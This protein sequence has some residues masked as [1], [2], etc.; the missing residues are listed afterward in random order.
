VNKLAALLSASA[1][2]FPAVAQ[3]Q[4]CRIDTIAGGGPSFAGNGGAALGAELRPGGSVLRD[5]GGLVHFI[6]YGSG[7]ILRITADERLETVVGSD[8]GQSGDGRPGPQTS[9]DFI[10][11]F[12]FAPDGALY[13]L[14]TSL[15]AELLRKL[16]LGGVVET[17]AGEHAADF[18]GDGGP[19]RD[20]GLGGTIDFTISP[21]GSIYL[22]SRAPSRTNTGRVRRISP[23]GLIETVAGGGDPFERAEVDWSETGPA[24]GALFEIPLQ[25]LAEPD[26]SVLVRDGGRAPLRRLRPDGTIEPTPFDLDRRLRIDGRGRLYWAEGDT[27]YRA[28]AD[29]RP[30]AIWTD[31]N[32]VRVVG[33][34]VDLDGNLWSGSGWGL[35][36]L[37]SDGRRLPAAGVSRTM[38][39]AG[40]GGPALQASFWPRHLSLGP[41]GELVLFDTATNRIRVV[42][43]GVISAVAGNGDLGPLVEGALAVETPLGGLAGGVSA[44]VEATAVLPNGEVLFATRGVIWRVGADSILSRFA[45]TPA[46]GCGASGFCRDGVP[47]RETGLGD[48][49]EMVVDGEGVVYLS[50][51]G[52]LDRILRSITPDGIITNI[53]FQWPTEQARLL[54]D[55]D[56]RLVIAQLHGRS[57]WRLTADGEILELPIGYPGSVSSWAVAPDGAFY[58]SKR[59]PKSIVRLTEDG[60]SETIVPES[61][62]IAPA[63]GD[64]G[65]AY[66]AV[67]VDPREFLI[68]RDGDLLVLDHTRIRRISNVAACSGPDGPRSRPYIS[69]AAGANR[70][71]PGSLFTLFGSELGPDQAVVASP[72]ASGRFPT[73]IAGT[74][75]LI[76]DRPAHLLFVSEGQINAVMPSS[77]ELVDHAVPR[78]DP[79]DLSRMW[80]TLIRVERNGRSS[81]PGPTLINGSSPAL[82][83][84]GGR[85]AAALNQDGTVNSASNPAA[86]G[87][88]VVLFG[89]GAGD[90][91]PPAETGAVVSSSPLPRVIAPVSVEF[92]GETAEVLYAGAAPGLVS[93]VLQVNA[94]I[95]VDQQSRGAAYVRLVV[96]PKS[97]QNQV[98]EIAIAE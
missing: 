94:R 39:L 17:V 54:I 57:F 52:G 74:R 14:E 5:P 97:N 90:M 15:G 24:L 23:D 18:S 16:P 81:P 12:A 7:R 28:D 20:A 48:R 19:A 82:F 75:V 10:R 9:T 51:R 93:G 68:N 40:D 91:D 47:A 62:S 32:G 1:L 78:A 79:Q 92:A 33:L 8:D 27:V 73:E 63:S 96:G 60:G 37:A 86:P 43:D 67:L 29:F 98:L 42:R 66:D 58:A 21:D 30:E 71:A 72:D 53:D 11:T 69:N 46:Q 83:R 85:Q 80:E 31:P 87:S 49:I 38:V 41:D 61:I 64:G 22:L 36:R 25:V 56:G 2:I 59:F 6:D 55:P 65:P 76:G 70:A 89:S 26:G 35:D 88:V 34:A 95:P 44:P 4:A 77:E 50:H 45:G 3:P 13:W 84:L